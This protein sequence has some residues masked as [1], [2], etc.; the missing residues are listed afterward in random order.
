VTAPDVDLPPGARLLDTED[1]VQRLL[2]ADHKGWQ[3]GDLA[4][5]KELIDAVRAG[6]L[7]AVLRVDGSLGFIPLACACD[8]E[9]TCEGDE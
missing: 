2:F 1:A 7:A 5:D 8:D 3:H 6:D 9:C 4:L